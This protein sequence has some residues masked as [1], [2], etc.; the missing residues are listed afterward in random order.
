V[1]GGQLSYRRKRRLVALGGVGIVASGIAVAILLLPTG[2]KLDQG[3]TGPPPA[4]Q[5]QPSA[6]PHNTR[7]S[8]AEDRRLMASIS[9]FV[10]TSVARNHPERSWPIVDSRLREGMTRR[11]W[12][13]G[14]IPVVPYPAVGFDLIKLQSVIG[15]TALVE[16][17][18]EPKRTAHLVRKTFQ[19]ELRR[20]PRP[21]HLWAVSSW[22]PEGVSQSQI[23]A[24]TPSSPAVAA[25]AANPPR[26][27][28][29]WILLPVGALVAGLIL[30]PAFM[31]TRDARRFRRAGQSR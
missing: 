1:R 27:S 24:N 15:R 31:L 4:A 29:L 20:E 5:S 13:T 7:L 25:A 6:Q 3:P 30:I 16:V 19:I 26:L 9:L 18:L 12:S 2:K 23:E 22:V 17:M 21:P 14:N 10:R 8:A 28:T 11:Q